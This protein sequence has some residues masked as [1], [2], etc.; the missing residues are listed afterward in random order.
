MP[1]RSTIT[2]R[3][4]ISLACLTW[5]VLSAERA[6]AAPLYT[7]T[8]LGEFQPGAPGYINYQYYHPL[9][10]T[11]T[12]QVLHSW[13]TSAGDYKAYTESYF[14]HQGDRSPSLGLYVQK[15]GEGPRFMT[16]VMENV[17]KL[18]SYEQVPSVTSVTSSGVF[19]EQRNGDSIVYNY[20][21]GTGV[22]AIG[23]PESPAIALGINNRNQLV[24]LMVP[25]NG[26]GLDHASLTTLPS[27][28]ISGPIVAPTV[29]LNTLIPPNSGWT[30][31]EA[32]GINDQGQIVGYGTAPDGT[33]HDYELNPLAQPVPE[34]TVFAFFGL[35]AAALAARAAARRRR[36]SK[37]ANTTTD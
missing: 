1:G 14:A 35:V 16:D 26:N 24:G 12:G 15:A 29:D 21:N 32:S 7:I 5:L 18:N 3:L 23:S 2:T 17:A 6:G 4:A 10:I 11:N 19:V 33:L 27:T 22:Y 36:G 28:L 9:T 37:T 25:V 8:D 13:T 20:A 31:M 34:P 30:L